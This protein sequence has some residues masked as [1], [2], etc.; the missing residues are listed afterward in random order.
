[1]PAVYSNCRLRRTFRGARGFTLVELLVVIA[2]IGILMS[3]LLPAVQAVRESARRTHCKNNLKQIGLAMTQY[4]DVNHRL[5]PSRPADCFLTWY[6]FIMPYLE[7]SSAFFRFDV[8][9]DYASQDPDAVKTNVPT[10]F[11]TSRRFSGNSVFESTGE[12]IGSVGDYVGNAGSS[13][14]FLGDQWALFDG[15][16]DGV[17]NSGYAWDNPIVA[18]RLVRAP[19]GRYGLNNVKDG[20]SYTLLV[21]EKAV[22]WEQLGMPGGWGDGSIFNGNEPASSMRLGGIGMGLAQNDAVPAP[23]PGSIPVFGS[24]HPG[25]VNFVF[26]D[27]HMASVPKSVDTDTLRL[28]CSRRDGEPNREF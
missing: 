15:D 18:G 14:Y 17:I 3:I 8:L 9:A 4:H 1:M 26:V 21:G 23:G 13:E 19:K 16:V 2:I 20:T 28:L 5:P 10:Y 22:S 24:A 7:E 12:P 27:G 6:V 11:C 25:V